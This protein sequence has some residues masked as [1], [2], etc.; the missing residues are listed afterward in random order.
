MKT[1]FTLPFLPS[2]GAWGGHGGHARSGK[3]SE[4]Q[5]EAEKLNFYL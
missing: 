4:K 1:N 2:E 3:T 5:K